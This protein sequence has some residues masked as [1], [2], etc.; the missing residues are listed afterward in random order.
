MVAQVPGGIGHRQGNRYAEQHAVAHLPRPRRPDEQTIEQVTPH[1]HQRQQRQIRQVLIG[2][3]AHAFDIGLHVD[4][5]VP[6]KQKQHGKATAG[7]QRPAASHGQRA[8]QGLAITGTDGM[9]AQG[10][11]RMG[12]AIEGIGGKQQ[13]IEQQGIG[14]NGSLTQACAL[15][16][17][18]EEHRL[19]GQAADEDVAVDGQ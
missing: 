2:R 12:Q 1:R 14:G 11:D 3:C 15:H 5:Q 8:T 17:D 9:A 6:A 16:G 10:L 4:K 13:T 7:Q 19:Q 18:Q